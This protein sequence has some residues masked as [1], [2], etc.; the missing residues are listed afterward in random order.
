MASRIARVAAA[1]L[2]LLGACWA[3]MAADDSPESLEQQVKAAFL[4]KFIGYVEWP[5]EAFADPGS[6]LVIGVAGD[7]SLAQ[8]LG[9]VIAR[10]TMNG[11]AVSVRQ[12]RSGESLAGIHMLF[13]SRSQLARLG[14]LSAHP[15]PVL[16]VTDVAKGLEQG[17]AINFVTAGNRV[18]FEVSLDAAKRNGLKIGAP[19]LSVAMRVQE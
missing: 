13:A 17:S 6:P 1:V 5:A 16:A 9:R 12:L 8:E 14:E 3:A 19:L 15:R 7:D 18:R 11:R 10:R 2:L 4:F